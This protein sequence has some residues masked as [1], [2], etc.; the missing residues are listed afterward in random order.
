MKMQAEPSTAPKVRTVCAFSLPSRVFCQLSIHRRLRDYTS[1]RHLEM[2]SILAD[3]EDDT[4]GNGEKVGGF[5][6][7]RTS[8]AIE[9]T[10]SK[11]SLF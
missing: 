7:I 1:D 2:A 4:G 8:A 10:V 5:E 9:S 6:E 11:S 3:P